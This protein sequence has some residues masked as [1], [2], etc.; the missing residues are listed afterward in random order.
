MSPTKPYSLFAGDPG[1]KNKTRADSLRRR[2]PEEEARIGRPS[3]RLTREAQ[4]F[5]NCKVPCPRAMALQPRAYQLECVQELRKGNTIAARG[6]EKTRE[7]P[8]FGGTEKHIF[9]SPGF[10]AIGRMFS[11]FCS[12]GAHVLC[13]PVL[14]LDSRESISPY[15]E[16]CAFFFS[17]GRRSKF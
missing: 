7:K 10:G 17:R 9:C 14:F 16:V 6:R 8:G 3:S 11:F 2:G 1:T 4:P 15:W 13:S 5:R 12:Q